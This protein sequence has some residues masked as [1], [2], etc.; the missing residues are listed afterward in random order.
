MLRIETEVSIEQFKDLLR[1]CGNLLGKTQEFLQTAAGES[2]DVLGLLEV[3]KQLIN[4]ILESPMSVEVGKSPMDGK[5]DELLGLYDEYTGTVAKS[6]YMP[7]TDELILLSSWAD[8]PKKL[9]IA[10]DRLDRVHFDKVLEQIGTRKMPCVMRR[11]P[12]K[13][14]ADKYVKLDGST[15]YVRKF[16]NTKYMFKEIRRLLEVWDSLNPAYPM[17]ADIKFMCYKENADEVLSETEAQDE[18]LDYIEED[19]AFED[20]VQDNSK[21]EVD[22]ASQGS[23]VV[24]DTRDEFSAN[25]KSEVVFKC[26]SLGDSDV[27]DGKIEAIVL[28]GKEYKTKWCD[29]VATTCRALNMV[30]PSNEVTA[31]V[32]KLQREYRPYILTKNDPEASDRSKYIFE[33]STHL[34]CRKAKG[35]KNAIKALRKILSLMRIQ[36]SRLCI[37]V[38]VSEN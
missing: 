23:D 17:C 28:D 33:N 14:I 32:A 25:N 31:S 16:S 8:L 3:R 26:F 5:K 9:C 13:K 19:E 10:L 15:L 12:R 22:T 36:P 4:N 24:G 35:S 7:P 34:Y 38:R 18:V 27:P 11:K 1:D 29:I 30:L 20:S 6:M 2:S 37:K 21:I